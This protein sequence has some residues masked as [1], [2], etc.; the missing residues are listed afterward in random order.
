[1]AGFALAKVPITEIVRTESALALL[2]EDASKVTELVDR[3]QSITDKLK[4]YQ[5]E[6]D[7]SARQVTDMIAGALEIKDALEKRRVAAKAESLKKCK[8]IDGLY[9][10]GVHAAD[11]LKKDGTAKVGEY[12]KK[13]QELVAKVLEAQLALQ[14]ESEKLRAAG[15]VEE[16]FA[17]QVQAN[18]AAPVEAVVSGVRGDFGKVSNKSVRKVTITDIHKV[19]RQF[20]EEALMDEELK[21][22][23]KEENGPLT[24]TLLKMWIL[25]VKHIEGADFTWDSVGTFKRGM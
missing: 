1:M 2:G 6:D 23:N 20:L 24:K 8:D 25:G 19:P 12:N 14:I 5:I 7:D 10:P 21:A 17:V 18:K 9:N 3:L 15:K 16:A 22:K 13:K 4:V 11:Q